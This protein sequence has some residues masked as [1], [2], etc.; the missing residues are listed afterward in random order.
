MHPPNVSLRDNPL[1]IMAEDAGELPRVAKALCLLLLVQHSTPFAEPVTLGELL[2]EPVAVA[3]LV[4]S[5]VTLF[6][7]NQ[8]VPLLFIVVVV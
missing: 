4:D 2:K 7:N 5:D 1:E 6:A 8:I 3:G